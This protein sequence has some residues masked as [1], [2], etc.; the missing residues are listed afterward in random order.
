[1]SASELESIRTSLPK[2]PK[3]L[4]TRFWP[5]SPK[6]LIKDGQRP[7]TGES[8]PPGSPTQRGRKN[9]PGSF[10][11]LPQARTQETKYPGEK[12]GEN[13]STIPARKPTSGI[14]TSEERMHSPEPKPAQPTNLTGINPT[15]RD[16]VESI[17]S[18][19]PGLTHDQIQAANSIESEN[20]TQ[21]E[22]E[23]F[24]MVNQLVKDV[25]NLETQKDE[26]METLRA[27]EATLERE[28][29]DHD[30]KMQ[31]ADETMDRLRARVTDAAS[32]SAEM[33]TQS[34]LRRPETEIIKDW[35]SLSYDVRNLVSN[36]FK[37]IKETKMISWAKSQ[38][39][40]L[41]E[42]TPY[43]AQAAADSKCGMALIEAAIWNVLMKLVFGDSATNGAMCWA[44]RHSGKLSKLSREV[45]K[46]IPR[47]D[48]DEQA[49]LFHR[50]KALTT[51][52][53]SGIS[54]KQDREDRIAD[55][56]DELE[57]MMER[58]RSKLSFA[59]FRRELQSVVR[60]AIELDELFCGQEAWYR[61]A[62][63]AVGRYDIEVD[64]NT[65]SIA[66][67]GANTRNV[68]FLI[69]PCLCRAGGGRGEPYE[70]AFLLDN[71]VVWT[72]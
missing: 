49:P 60:Q 17:H 7:S 38:G 21:K 25:A 61:L 35:Q 12:M 48:W 16:T 4:L 33:P 37:G 27:T 59:S 13:L 65:M 20:R 57:S 22:D 2:S 50:W 47:K 42:L 46:D 19:G 34:P 23:L 54:L 53:V 5:R 52:L 15:R 32:K 58:F 39:H 9:S 70:K 1:M 64:R 18:T 28:R 8:A 31:E 67:G 30:N 72:Y 36:Y 69:R 41:E 68:R 63:P 40:Y 26:V 62:V 43:Y 66:G 29:L 56:T 11:N 14:S 45:F 6:S 3:Q 24:R 51:D 10:S 71:Y 55:V 44:G